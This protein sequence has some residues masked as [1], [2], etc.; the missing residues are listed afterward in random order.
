[1]R[2]LSLIVLFVASTTASFAV[3]FAKLS[4]NEPVSATY[5]ANFKCYIDVSFFLDLSSSQTNAAYVRFS[6]IIGQDT[7]NDMMKVDKSYN[8]VVKRIF[9]DEGEHLTASVQLANAEIE[10]IS[11]IDGSLRLVRNPEMEPTDDQGKNTFLGAIWKSDQTPLFRVVLKEGETSK[12]FKLT[13][14]LSENFEYDKLYLKAKVISPVAGIVMIDKT[15][16][17][18]EAKT[19]ERR[20]RSISLT[21]DEIQMSQA[22]SYYFQVMQNMSGARINGVEMVSYELVSE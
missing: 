13:V 16:N 15:L 6:Y 3:D 20:K 2:L 11:G 1:M 19:V 9:L 18:N 10:S 4:R 17:V 21:F 12:K 14:K 7:L 5:Q 22:G 8:A